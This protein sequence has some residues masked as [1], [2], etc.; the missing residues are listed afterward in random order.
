MNKKSFTLQELAEFT[1]SDLIGDP[2]Y[3]ITNVESLELAEGTDASFLS[4]PLSGFR[5]YE[6][7]MLKS[8]AGVVFISTADGLPPDRQFLVNGDPSSAFQKTAEAFYGTQQEFTGFSDIHPTAVIHPT[9]KVG[10]GCTIGPFAVIDKDVKIGDETT[11]SSGCYIGPSVQIGSNCLLHPRVTLRERCVLGNR[12]ILQPGVV[13]GA[14][15]FGYVTDKTGRHT[16][17]NQLGSVIIDDD[18]EIGANSTIDRSRFKNTQI[19]RGTK[20]DN[21]VQIGHGAIIGEDNIIVSQTGIAGSAKTGSR[22][23]IAAQAGVAG[24]LQIADNVVVA[25]RGGVTK[26]LMK[27][28]VYGGMPARSIDE[29]NRST[30]HFLNL[31]TYAKKLKELEKRIEKLES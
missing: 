2:N 24:H 11:V 5:G 31:S 7:A 3:C 22:V 23:T 19:G 4:K 25:G 18:V 9:A 10:R 29:H 12:V 20:I 27:A 26:S 1:G 21:L 28:G 15:G 17:L 8:K 13:I 6:K 16:K 30:V 14:C